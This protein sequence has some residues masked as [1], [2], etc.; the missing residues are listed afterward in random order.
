MTAAALLERGWTRESSAARNAAGENVDVL[1]EI[2]R[3][4]DRPS[5][6]QRRVSNLANLMT[7]RGLRVEE[8]TRV[9]LPD[10]RPFTVQRSIFFLAFAND[11]TLQFFSRP[12]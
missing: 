1:A 6:Q 10:S 8:S 3:A 4:F 2:F 12:S 11:R 5:I 7:P 9:C